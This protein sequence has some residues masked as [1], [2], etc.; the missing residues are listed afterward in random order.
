[1]LSELTLTIIGIRNRS[2]AEFAQPTQC[3]AE[4][5]VISALLLLQLEHMIVHAD[6]H[7]ADGKL[8]RDEF[9]KFILE[10]EDEVAEID[11]KMSK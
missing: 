1:M 9:F 4:S 3:C 6:K 10:H 11:E 7:C 8:S 5:I 2:H